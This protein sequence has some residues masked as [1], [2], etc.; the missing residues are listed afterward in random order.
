MLDAPYPESGSVLYLC[1]PAHLRRPRV[2]LDPQVF[3]PRT[4]SPGLPWSM[5]NKCKQVPEDLQTKLL[6]TAAKPS[7]LGE[8]RTLAW[9]RPL[10]QSKSPL[11]GNV[12]TKPLAYGD[13]QGALSH[14][15]TFTSGHQ[16]P[17]RCAHA[18]L[19]CLLLLSM[20]RDAELSAEARGPSEGLFR[21]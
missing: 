4:V 5:Q 2:D 16:L 7:Q 9:T 17:H 11:S 10:S 8:L 21:G 14:C 15:R 1:Q 13:G 18:W 6:S 19:L 3:P 12:K 20:R